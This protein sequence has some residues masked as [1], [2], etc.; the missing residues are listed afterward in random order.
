MSDEKTKPAFE[1]RLN[2]VRVSVWRNTSDSGVYYNTVIVRRY[3]DGDDWKDSHAFNGLA[4]LALVNEATRLAQGFI[5]QETMNA[6][7]EAE[8]TV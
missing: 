6:K 4:D 8:S 7:S 1:E 3:K 2:H 5:T